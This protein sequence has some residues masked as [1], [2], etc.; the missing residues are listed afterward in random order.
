MA[1]VIT[2]D[3]MRESYADIVRTVYDNGVESAPRGQ[4]VR[5]LRGVVIEL[6]NP[7]DAVPVG[8]GRELNMRIGA[9]ETV[10]L[11][12]GISDAQ[13]LINATST[14]KQFTNDGRLLGA[15]GPRAVDQL[16]HVIHTLSVDSDSRQA[17]ISIW[18]PDELSIESNDVPC[19]LSLDFMIRDNALHMYT[20]MRS[21]DVWLGVPYDFMMFTRLQIALAWA[22]GVDV[23][24]YTHFALNMHIYERDFA[25]INR[26]HAPQTDVLVPS[27]IG[28]GPPR[29]VG[30]QTAKLALNRWQN[31]KSQARGCVVDSRDPAK[32]SDSARWYYYQLQDAFSDGVLCSICLYVLPRDAFPNK[33]ARGH[34]MGR[35]GACLTEVR[36]R[37]RRENAPKIRAKRLAQ[38]GLTEESYAE[39]LQRQNNVCAICH[40]VP[41]SGPYK[42]F[43]IDHDHLT[44]HV[45]GL[46][47][48]KCNNGLG[49]LGDN[50]EGLESAVTYLRRAEHETNA[51]DA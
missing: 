14:F 1:T 42:D 22:L 50:L 25:K 30:H 4:R 16:T 11:I 23:G 17:A 5:E 44:G 41:S 46:L 15:Y 34:R 33:G 20:T 8:V 24:T 38:Y 39:L 37:K 31:V 10:H 49:L 9:A 7:L 43:V 3:S 6:S 29:Q 13:Q 28:G 35:C 12:G 48:N 18:R 32:M 40:E 26:L 21:N 47:C 51:T 27:F 45:R 36:Q 2:I 19:T